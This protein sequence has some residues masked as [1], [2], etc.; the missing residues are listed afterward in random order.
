MPIGVAFRRRDWEAGGTQFSAW[1]TE[2]I[3]LVPALLKSVGKPKKDS[4]VSYLVA[5]MKQEY[6]L[7]KKK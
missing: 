7:A 2:S 4:G 6:E 1:H 3:P 5:G